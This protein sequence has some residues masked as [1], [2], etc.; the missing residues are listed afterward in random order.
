[1][2]SV[3]RERAA[4]AVKAGKKRA[5]DFDIRLPGAAAGTEGF[6]TE[7][8]ADHGIASSYLRGHWPR[9]RAW[10]D[11]RHSPSATVGTRLAAS[12]WMRYHALA[13]DYDGTIAWDGRVSEPTINALQE[14]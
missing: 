8:Y 13:C 14:V 10:N 5:R 6:H 11:G 1:M 9:Q 3:H 4:G 7:V 12:N 2:R